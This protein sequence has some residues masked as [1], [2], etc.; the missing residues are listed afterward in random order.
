MV[1]ELGLPGCRAYLQVGCPWPHVAYASI[2]AQFL[3]SSCAQLFLRDDD[4]F[5]TSETL[6]RMHEQVEAGAAAV[7]APYLIRDGDR[8]DVLLEEDGRLKTAGVGCC[9]LRRRV[10]EVLWRVHNQELGWV[11]EGKPLVSIFHDF[12]AERDN[13]VE[14]KKYDEAFWYRV[15]AAGFAVEV[16][17]E[18]EV[19][20]AGVSAVFK[21]GKR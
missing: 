6:A 17:D 3:E 2:V 20:H 14:L 16:L 7:V 13:G 8:F 12:F 18:A 15:K 10:L 11:Q 9:L 19:S 21:K 1:E 5:P 4:V